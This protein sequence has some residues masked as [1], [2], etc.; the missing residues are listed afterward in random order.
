MDGLD[1]LLLGRGRRPSSRDASHTAP[2]ASIG[3]VRK[4]RAD[5]ERWTGAAQQGGL[6]R[7][8]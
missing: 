6:L 1:G 2:R 8:R 5:V 4:G 3:R 7:T